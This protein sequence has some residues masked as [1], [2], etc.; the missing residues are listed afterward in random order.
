VKKETGFFETKWILAD[1][2]W[3]VMATTRRKAGGAGLQGR[4]ET[5]IKEKRRPLLV[6][7]IPALGVRKFWRE[8]S[9]EKRRGQWG[10]TAQIKGQLNGSRCSEGG[11]RG[12]SELGLVVFH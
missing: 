7:A 8:K 2:A 3:T 5:I 12:R 4:E 6:D 9:E 11:K 1:G 10:G